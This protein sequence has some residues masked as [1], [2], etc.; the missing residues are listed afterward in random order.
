MQNTYM[1]LAQSTVSTVLLLRGY[2]DLN[3]YVMFHKLS[4]YAILYASSFFWRLLNVLSALSFTL[5]N[6][7]KWALFQYIV[8][9]S[10][11]K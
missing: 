2:S 1:V 5:K 7:G 10:Y 9:V 8:M 11:V 6:S 3:A 4:P